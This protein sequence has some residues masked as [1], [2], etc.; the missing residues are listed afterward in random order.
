MSMKLKVFLLILSFV[1]AG[2][3]IPHDF[4]FAQEEAEDIKT[5]PVQDFGVFDVQ[6]EVRQENEEPELLITWDTAD[7]L[8]QTAFQVLISSN[9]QYTEDTIGDIYD[10]GK[11]ESEEHHVLIPESKIFTKE[12]K[13]GFYTFQL[14]V[15]DQHDQPGP[16]IEPLRQYILTESFSG[17][18]QGTPREPRALYGEAIDTTT[19]AWHFEDQSDNETGYAIFD[20]QGKVVVTTAG[21]DV[22]DLD[23]LLETD[24]AP[25]KKYEGRTVRSF[26]PFGFSEEI[27]TPF[28]P[29][30][31]RAE[32]P[33]VPILYQVSADRLKLSISPNNNPSHTE[34]AVYD[35]ERKEYLSPTGSFSPEASWGD[36]AAWQELELSFNGDER[37][38]LAVKARNGDKIETV[39]SPIAVLGEKPEEK[40]AVG[41]S[42]TSGL[43]LPPEQGEAVSPEFT[44]LGMTR[45][46][47]RYLLF[48]G[49]FLFAA[50]VYFTLR[51]I[52]GDVVTTVQ[53]LPIALFSHH[54][55]T[56]ASHVDSRYVGE[57]AY[58]AVIS[59]AQISM[60]LVLITSSL[61]IG[62]DIMSK[63]SYA[64]VSPEQTE[65][66]SELRAG[67]VVTYIIHYAPKDP[68]DEVLTISL[69][70]QTALQQLSVSDAHISK[71]SGMGFI[72]L[73]VPKR[74][75]AA[76]IRFQLVVKDNMYY[77]GTEITP[78]IS[79]ANSKVITTLDTYKI[80]DTSQSLAGAVVSLDREPEVFFIGKDG[81]RHQFPTE[82]EFYSWGYDFTDVITVPQ[83]I[84][85]IYLPGD[86]MKFKSGSLVRL[87]E[88]DSYIYR[89][90]SDGE[91]LELVENINT[92]TPIYPINFNQLNS[93]Q[94]RY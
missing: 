94:I 3:I 73:D 4:V 79:D 72:R 75:D 48:I 84:L 31:T 57:P 39:N 89:V 47:T 23:H 87:N 56:Y 36:L 66:K 35:V 77:G 59:I 26:N 51:I 34:Y 40:P 55:A 76:E 37:Y 18:I 58:A 33:G 65:L 50:G 24:L 82:Q 12:L 27:S 2:I 62:L 74:V 17:V 19:I 91:G 90:S 16:Y 8:V 60:L 11:V 86:E 68:R 54:K 5:V 15:W 42:A 32:A 9:P 13:N 71:D 29:V 10:S 44:F 64:T 6:I 43:N 49:L 61:S 22:Q 41:L 70:H 92:E 46:V 38:T 30:Y 85:E 63:R 52:D 67:D 14:K 21:A 53:K 80:A 88:G 1:G 69:P 93:Y 28:H 78:T 20:D 25:N 83:S 45:E 81:K 7:E